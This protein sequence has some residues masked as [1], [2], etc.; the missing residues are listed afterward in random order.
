MHYAGTSLRSLELR[1]SPLFLCQLCHLPSE[2]RLS[3]RRWAT[4]PLVKD[5]HDDDMFVVH[6]V[7]Q[8]VR[9]VGD[10]PLQHIPARVIWT[11]MPDV[12]LVDQ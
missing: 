1:G 5:P 10:I 11:D 6:H 4:L 9:G 7:G 3:P 8:G 2:G 12:W